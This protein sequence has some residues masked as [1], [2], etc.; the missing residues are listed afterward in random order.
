MDHSLHRFQYG[1]VLSFSYTVWFQHLCRSSQTLLRYILLHYLTWVSW[2]FFWKTS[3][4]RLWIPWTYWTLHLNSSRNISKFYESNHQWMIHNIH[5]PLMEDDGIGPHTY[6]WMSSRTPSVLLSCFE[7]GFLIF[8]PCA[9]P[10][11][12]PLW[13]P[14]SSGKPVTAL[15]MYGSVL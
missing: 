2:F 14:L 7:K 1:Y 11:H 15:H 5:T 13:S 4:S 10:L 6:E 12:T 8:F 9:H 3:L